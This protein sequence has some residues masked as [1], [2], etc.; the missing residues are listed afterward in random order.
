MLEDRIGDT[1]QGMSEVEMDQKFG[2]SKYDYQNKTT[3]DSCNGYS[4]KTVVSSLGENDLDI[5]RDRNV[6]IEH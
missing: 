3:D 5:P 4:K 6:E 2:H 1:S